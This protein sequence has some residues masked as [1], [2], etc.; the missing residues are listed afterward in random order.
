[1]EAIG[2]LT[3]GVA[4][5]FNNL[6]TVVTGSLDIARR[7]L[8]A[9]DEARTQ[10]QIDNAL[11]GA[12]RAAALTQRLLAFSRR[13]P[14]TPQAL[15]IN[16]LVTSIGGDLL[17]RTLGEA[18]ALET[19][20]A[21]DLWPATADRNQ[22]EN[23][24]LNLA[25]NARDAMA[26][27]ADGRLTLRTANRTL[28]APA[29]ARAGV[30]PGRYVEIAVTDTGDG[31]PPEAM[32]K[33]FEPFFTTKEQGKGTGLGLPTVFGFMR[34]SGGAVLVDS[35]VGVGTTVRL[36]LPAAADGA[37]EPARESADEAAPVEEA[38]SWAGGPLTV[39]VVEDQEAVA[40]LAE[41]VLT[42][43]GYRVL[44]APDGPSGLSLLTGDGG[45]EIGLLFSDVVMPGG[46]SGL[47]LARAA[48]ERRPNLPI[49][50]TTGYAH[51]SIGLHG[52][53]GRVPV[54]PILDKPYRRT[55]LLAKV[56][57]VLGLEAGG[58]ARIARSAD[59]RRAGRA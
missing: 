49:L 44:R 35:T 57:E 59:A 29:A 58:A 46:M 47:D 10:R 41:A 32:A 50:L 42:D 36:L 14:L 12:Q 51:A 56:D 30:A 20:A 1:M 3:G 11:K 27:R 55:D 2:Q 33:I 24:I 19:V 54:F 17:A 25:V 5:D 15:D 40:D 43:A 16:D 9:G 21:S 23:A 37:D 18:I 53:G 22:L 38:R 48:R 6:L 4:H 52:E 13:Q 39:L 8:A 34:Q 45:V 7:S 31:I 28:D 26:E